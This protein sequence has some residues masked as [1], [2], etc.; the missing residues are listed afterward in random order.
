MHKVAGRTA[1]DN[2]QKPPSCH[3]Y[4]Q[5]HHLLL[6][7][8]PGH[9]WLVSATFVDRSKSLNQPSLTGTAACLVELASAQVYVEIALV[10]SLPNKLQRVISN[11]RPLRL[12]SG[13]CNKKTRS[14]IESL[15]DHRSNII[16]ICCSSDVR[17]LGKIPLKH[18]CERLSRFSIFQEASIYPTFISGGCD[19]NIERQLCN[20][21]EMVRNQR[22]Q[23]A[24][25]KVLDGIHEKPCCQQEV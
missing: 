15:R 8:I 10:P 6:A 21:K 11:P 25:P 14:I 13:S 17:P 20:D 22:R 24:T 12:R 4:K 23:A 18:L 9:A 19:H 16:D 3:R 5:V 2:A 7:A 1:Q